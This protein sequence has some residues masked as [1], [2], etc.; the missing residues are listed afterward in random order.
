[1]K[2]GWTKQYEATGACK[3]FEWERRVKL[4]VKEKGCTNLLYDQNWLAI[5][6]TQIKKNK[7]QLAPL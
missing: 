6:L 5:K 1:M 7:K 3:M 4:N 2:N